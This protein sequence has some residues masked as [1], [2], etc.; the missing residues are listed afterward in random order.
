MWDWK[1][2]KGSVVLGRDG[3]TVRS[4]RVGMGQLV[5]C[6]QQ[7]LVLPQGFAQGIVQVENQLGTSWSGARG[8][9]HSHEMSE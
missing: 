4:E 5:P 7:G 3:G 8:G 1:G 6:P 9:N 2:E